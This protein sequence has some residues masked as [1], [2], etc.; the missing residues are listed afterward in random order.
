MLLQKPI[1]HKRLSNIDLKQ[2]PNQLDDKYVNN[3]FHIYK[4]SWDDLRKVLNPYF[5]T[6]CSGNSLYSKHQDKDK[7]DKIVENWNSGIALIPPM[8]IHLPDN[9]LFPADGKHRMKAAFVGDRSEIY[10]ILFDIDLL[11]INKYFKP[12]LVE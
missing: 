2:Q 9:T 8:L 4:S 1:W 6:I 12:E 3:G 5:A 10:F 11:S 7:L